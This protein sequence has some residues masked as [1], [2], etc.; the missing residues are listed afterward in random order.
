MQ[1]ALRSGD[2][3][4]SLFSMNLIRSHW[5]HKWFNLIMG[6]R[7][8]IWHFFVQRSVLNW[9]Y[10]W[11]FFDFLRFIHRPLYNASWYGRPTNPVGSSSGLVVVQL[12]IRTW[13][14]A[15]EHLRQSWTNRSL[16]SKA[17]Q[18]SSVAPDWFGADECHQRYRYTGTE[19]GSSVCE[20]LHDVLQREWF[21]L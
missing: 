7:Q 20:K 13:P 5:P 16:G 17:P 18:H 19:R 21:A 15:S 12:Q 11:S 8:L 10:T 6:H 9:N 1:C 3:M 14:S 4:Q 2:L